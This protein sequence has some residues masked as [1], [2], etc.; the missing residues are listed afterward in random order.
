M[1]SR[2]LG[3]KLN[4]LTNAKTEFTRE[5]GANQRLFK[6]DRRRHI[7]SLEHIKVE[8]EMKNL[9]ERRRMSTTL[10]TLNIAQDIADAAKVRD[11]LP[12]LLHLYVVKVYIKKER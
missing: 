4:T 3:L 9:E 2:H 7:E 5:F 11:M 1:E 10:S 6:L 8:T 12:Y